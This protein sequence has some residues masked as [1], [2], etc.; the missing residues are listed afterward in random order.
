MKKNLS[1]YIF[2][3]VFT[4]LYAQK[5]FKGG[6][7]YSN[8]KVLYGKFEMRMKMIKG[9][10]MLSTFY[11]IE[12]KSKIKNHWSEIDIEVLGKENAQILSTNMFIN[13]KNGELLHTVL[14]VNLDYS[15]ADDFHTYTLEWTPEYVAWFIDGK[16]I[17]RKTGDFVN[18]M[19]IPQEYRFNAWISSTPAW[20]GTID[21]SAM[22]AYQYVDWVAY[23]SYNDSTKDFTKQWR[24]EFNSFDKK[25]WKKGDWTF[26]GNEVDF[27]E[28]NVFIENG[29]LVLAI[30][31]SKEE[32]ET[33]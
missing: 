32:K 25:R 26:D 3:F 22:P 19:N 8:E 7:I 4:S 31:E 16:E 24:D 14:E 27:V 30:T 11:T 2:I 29:K 10:G 18:H 20:V 1:T 33:K 28:E 6:E 5:P 13:D 15:L 9:G 23:S 17:R 12:H 21:T